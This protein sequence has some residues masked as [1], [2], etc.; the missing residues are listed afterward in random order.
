MVDFGTS[1]CVDVVS[2]KGE[3]LGG[4]IAPGLEISSDA[5]A[6]QSAALRKVELVRPR[7]VVGKNTVE[8]MQSGAVFG[9]AGLVDGLVRRVR[10]ELPAF[11]GSDVAVVA[12]GDRAPLIMP[13]TETVDSTNRISRS[14]GCAWSTSAIR[15]DGGRV[16]A[17][18][19]D[20][21]PSSRVMSEWSP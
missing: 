1:T 20:G 11:A 21:Y 17:R 4:A 10:D 13:E 16:A 5:L 18:S 9:F 3:F 8:C 2:A 6:S 15:L 7:S 19:S 14:K 12:T